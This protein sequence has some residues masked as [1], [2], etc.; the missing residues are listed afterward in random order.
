MIRPASI[1]D[2]RAL[3]KARL[4]RQ[5]FDYLDG[6]SYA[7]ETLHANIADF[8]ALKFRQRVMRD[9]SRLDTRT[10]VLGHDLAIPVV[11]SPVGFAGMFARR[12]EVQAARAAQAFGVPFTLSTVGIC[13]AAEIRA[14]TTAPFW[15]QLYMVRDRGVVRTIL[16]RAAEAAC[17][18]LVFTV[19]LPVLGTRYRDIRNGMG[20]A[21]LGARLG[22]AWQYLSHPAWL[23]DVGLNGRPHSFGN[24][25]EFMTGTLGPAALGAWVA[26]QMDASVTWADIAFVRETWKGPLIIKGILDVEDARQAVAAGA[27]AI[28]VSNHGGR[29]LDGAPSSISVLPRIAG[30]VGDRTVVLMDGGV[31]TGNDIVKALASGA[32]A[33]LI[34]RAW[35]FGLAA[36]GGAGVTAVLETL[37]AELRTT[38]ALIG[39]TTV[40]AVTPD[41]LAA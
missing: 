31:R 35:A 19:D 4:P 24:L 20:G 39:A 1:G 40:D 38:M 30:A 23:W 41:V 21:S 17:S 6:G 28:V 22:N 11:L 16:A 15:Y 5:F 27:D 26:G 2:F 14:A 9:V 32:K 18:A 33:C 3:A 12:G 34:G 10:R 13:K 25:E 29:Q 36:R 8:G 7:E 37:Q